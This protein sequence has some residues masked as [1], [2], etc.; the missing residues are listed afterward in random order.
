MNIYEKMLAAYL[1][2]SPNEVT[3]EELQQAI[4]LKLA[5]KAKKEEAAQN[6]ENGNA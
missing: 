6:G 1:K 2:K 3:A 4:N 5:R